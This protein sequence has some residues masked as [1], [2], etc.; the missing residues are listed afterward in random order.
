MRESIR[1]YTEGVIEQLQAAGPG[2]LAQAASELAAVNDVVAG[3]DDLCRALSDPG[4]PPASRRGLMSDL[5]SSHVSSDSLRL[6]T[7][8]VDA[9]RASDTADEIAWL[10]VGVDA[11]AKNLV[12]IGEAVLGR[13]AAEE[14]IDGYAT[15]VLSEL[16]GERDL[17]T[18]EDELFR[19][20]RTVQGSSELT[21]ALSSRTIPVARRKALVRDLLQT[22]ST[23]ATVRLASYA[24]QVGRPREY[25]D[26]L[27]FVVDRVASESNRRVAEVRSAVEIDD[28]QRARLARALAAVVGRDVDIRVTVDRSVL[29]GFVATIGDTVIDGTSRHRFEV[30][31][32]RL[33]TPEAALTIG[34]TG[35][36]TDG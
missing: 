12:P 25:E 20:L 32:E 35:D 3:S 17:V 9:G 36:S 4:L 22:R 30:L 1:G 18:V 6:L 19:F 34:T 27:S 7:F 10:A 16:H 23:P 28:E 15:A 21:S 26:L 5:F 29:G 33:V 8:V 11:A 2:R 31:K 14:R 24:T 13:K